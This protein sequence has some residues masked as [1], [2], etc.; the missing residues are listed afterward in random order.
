MKTPYL[1]FLVGILGFTF[2][3]VF[4]VMG[5]GELKVC[6]TCGWLGQANQVFF[7]FGIGLVVSSLRFMGTFTICKKGV[8]YNVCLHSVVALHIVVK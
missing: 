2:S 5:V 8:K 4:S 6:E 1:I 3:I 7:H